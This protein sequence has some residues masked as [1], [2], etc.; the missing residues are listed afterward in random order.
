MTVETEKKYELRGLKATDFFLM[1]RIVSKMGV[2]EL[3]GIFENEDTKAIIKDMM[4]KNNGEL[5]VS[6]LTSIGI[7]ATIDVVATVLDHMEAC[8]KDVYKLLSRLSGLTEAEIADLPMDVFGEMVISVINH[9][10]F[11]DFFTAVVKQFK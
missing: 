2:K 3:K 9:E 5:A 8:E 6:D 10:G 11:R 4:E 7:G 1:T